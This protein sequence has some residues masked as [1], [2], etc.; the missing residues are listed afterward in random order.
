MIPKEFI[1]P[2]PGGCGRCER[3][4]PPGQNEYCWF[5]TG[6]L[7]I[8]CWEKYGHCGHKKAEAENE[9]VKDKGKQ[10]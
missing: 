3:P 4:I 1:K 6:M 9:R 2:I 10:K 7:C 5:C 8:E